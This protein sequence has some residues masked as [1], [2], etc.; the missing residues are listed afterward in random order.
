VVTV[1]RDVLPLQSLPCRP[2]YSLLDMTVLVLAAYDEAD[3][4]A[5]FW[6]IVTLKDKAF[7][8]CLNEGEASR[9][10]GEDGGHAASDD[11]LESLDELH[12]TAQIEFSFYERYFNP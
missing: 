4:F 3:V 2:K 6:R 9:N 7:V 1:A 12:L 5:F 8:L 11:L 10:A